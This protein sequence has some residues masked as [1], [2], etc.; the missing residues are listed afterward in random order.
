MYLSGSST[1]ERDMANVARELLSDKTAELD[2]EDMDRVTDY[3]DLILLAK[4]GRRFLNC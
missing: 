2:V 1:D 4:R 3:V